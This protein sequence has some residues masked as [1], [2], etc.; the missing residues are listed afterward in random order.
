M[1]GKLGALKAYRS[2]R[3]LCDRY[4]EKWHRGHTCNATVQL[5]AI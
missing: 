5:H 4:A 2:A 1:D 3:G